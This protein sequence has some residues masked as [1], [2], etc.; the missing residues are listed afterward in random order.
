[1]FD[2]KYYQDK[3]QELEKKFQENKD[4]LIADMTNLMNKFYANQKDLSDRF[5]ELKAREEESQKKTEEQNKA[6]ID[7]KIKGG[8]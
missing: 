5:T 7:K 1:M 4:T 2:A 3:R 8:K 6:E